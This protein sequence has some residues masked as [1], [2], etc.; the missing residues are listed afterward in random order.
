M[1]FKKKRTGL[2]A[3]KARIAIKGLSCIDMRTLAAQALLSWKRSLI[4]DLGGERG[5][6]AQQECLIELAVRSRLLIEHLD[7]FLLA[8]PSLINKKRRSCYPVLSQRQHLVDSLARILGQLGLKKMPKDMGSLDDYLKEKEGEHKHLA[9]NAG[10]ETVED[11][12]AEEGVTEPEV[13]A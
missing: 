1:A 9:G 12:P 10:S 4:Q 7:A 13:S 2:N 3:L 8:E 6:S 5:I 11:V